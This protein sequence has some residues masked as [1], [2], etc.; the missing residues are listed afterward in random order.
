VRAEGFMR[1]L[2]AASL[3]I[4]ALSLSA[5]ADGIPAG[6]GQPERFSWTGLY[7]G[8]NVGWTQ[9]DVDWSF[10]FAAANSTQSTS[11]S[12]ESII[13]GGQ[14]GAQ[15]QMGAVVLGVEAAWSATR[16]DREESNC[17]FPAPF[18]D[19]CDSKLDNSLFTAGGRLGWAA[20]NKWLVFGTGGWAF[21]RIGADIRFGGVGVP[22]APNAIPVI[23]D[24]KSQ[25]GWYVGGG[26]EYALT[27]NLI[28][29]AEYQRINLDSERHLVPVG[30]APSILTA[31]IDADIDI[32]RA[33]I[34][35]KFGDSREATPLK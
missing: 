7:F 34:S 32:V 12:D 6:N 2:V 21:T 23:V 1:V 35:Y 33:R 25:D 14:I 18:T 29:G 10:P 17:A 16:P 31:D 15:Y 22:P 19:R 8:A 13:G 28:L 24:R 3:A 30:G 11:Q 5:R 4:A 27:S 9:S 26:V 20:S